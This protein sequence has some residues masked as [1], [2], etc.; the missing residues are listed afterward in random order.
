MASSAVTLRIFSKSNCVHTMALSNF[1]DWHSLN[2]WSL[3]SGLKD[4]LAWE[5]SLI[6]IDAV[7]DEN[8]HNNQGNG[9][10]AS[11]SVESARVSCSDVNSLSD[12]RSGQEPKSDCSLAETNVLLSLCWELDG[13]D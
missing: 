9:E 1:V 11:H 12:K 3:L 6:G 7:R 13:D 4:L 10:D 2:R 8:S 5:L